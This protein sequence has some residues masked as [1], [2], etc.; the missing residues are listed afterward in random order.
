MKY[1][2]LFHKNRQIEIFIHHILYLICSIDSNNQYKTYK[3]PPKLSK[4]SN[5]N[6]DSSAISEKKRHTNDAFWLVNVSAS[7]P[8][9]LVEF[10]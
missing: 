9:L 8:G 3:N 7:V 1:L 4:I 10:A 6:Y 5:N 2:Y